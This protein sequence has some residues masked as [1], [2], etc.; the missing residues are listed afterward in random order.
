[1]YRCVISYVAQDVP[2]DDVVA[3]DVPQS[4]GVV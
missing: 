4:D 1:M 3:I 2:V